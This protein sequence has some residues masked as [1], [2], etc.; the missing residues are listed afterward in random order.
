MTE[1]STAPTFEP[2]EGLTRLVIRGALLSLVT[3]GLY[4]PWAWLSWYREIFGAI[5]ILGDPLVHRGSAAEYVARV[6]VFWTALV[7]GF[8]SPDNSSLLLDPMGQPDPLGWAIYLG[9]VLALGNAIKN[10]ILHFSTSETT[11]RN[12]PVSLLEK[13]ERRTE[14]TG[15][16]AAIWICGYLALAV[17][18]LLI[19]DWYFAYGSEG[20]VRLF[21]LMSPFSGTPVPGMMLCHF[22]FGLIC[23]ALNTLEFS[24][25][26]A[27]SQASRYGD[28]RMVVNV[29][30]TAYVTVS[31][32]ASIAIIATFVGL[33]FT[34]SHLADLLPHTPTA[35]I[36]VFG[37][38]VAITATVRAIVREA[39]LE[40][41]KVAYILDHVRLEKIPRRDTTQPS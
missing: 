41:W 14:R 18:Y 37:V 8:L 40:P 21:F 22:A 35:R 25:R 9:G 11:W 38:V 13:S 36:S 12:S 7:G 26:C 32:A 34:A 17:G 10:S 39:W 29:P 30:I 33:L 23:I 6:S 27:S 28:M 1:T 4:R 24:S 2:P 16:V 15:V 3:L 20:V 31:T 19:A 5:R